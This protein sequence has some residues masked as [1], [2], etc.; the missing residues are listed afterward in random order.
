T[1]LI[2]YKAANYKEAI[3]AFKAAINL[4]PDYAEAFR[5]LG[6]AYFNLEKFKEAEASFNQSFKLK[7]QI[8][9]DSY[10]SDWADALINLAVIYS[11]EKDHFRALAIFSSVIRR[12]AGAK[13][14]EIIELK[15][16]NAVVYYDLGTT[17]Y[18][19]RGANE[20]YERRLNAAVEC[21][22]KAIA[23]KSDY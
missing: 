11:I 17:Y 8:S 22:K 16:D 9:W 15:V 21:F 19:N 7:G 2:Y 1:G 13:I 14:D 6:N 12:R 3:E 20:E 10:E 4:K 18:T 23:L 5:D